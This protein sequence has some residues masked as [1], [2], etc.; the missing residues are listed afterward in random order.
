MREAATL[1]RDRPLP[2]RGDVNCLHLSAG[3]WCCRRESPTGR[4]AIAAQTSPKS[5]ASHSSLGSIG[6]KLGK[7]HWSVYGYKRMSLPAMR[8]AE[9]DSREP[10]AG[11]N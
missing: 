7:I 2:N 1:S 6:K 8:R 4:N 5:A 10:P 3:K 9:L 11:K